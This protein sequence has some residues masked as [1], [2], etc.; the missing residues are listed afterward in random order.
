MVVLR[1]DVTSEVAD[2]VEDV[3]V[4]GITEDVVGAEVVVDITSDED[5]ELEETLGTEDDTVVL[6]EVAVEP[7]E[8]MRSVTA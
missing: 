4:D 5:F 8:A 3:S 7:T 6:R 2:A 1:V